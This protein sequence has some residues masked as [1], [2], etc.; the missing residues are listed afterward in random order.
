MDVISNLK[1]VYYFAKR[2]GRVAV[3]DQDKAAYTGE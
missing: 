2:I 1:R 3:P